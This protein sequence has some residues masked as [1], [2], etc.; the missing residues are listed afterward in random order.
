MP[1]IKELLN[2]LFTLRGV[3]SKKT[4]LIIEIIGI[5]LILSIWTIAA[6]LKNNHIVFPS[7]FDILYSFKELHFKNYLIQN[8]L[9]SIK[10]NLL[11]YLE[12][13]VIAIPIGFVLGLFPLFRALFSKYINAIRFIPLTAITGL[14]ILWFGIGMNMKIQF[15]AVGILVYLLPVIIQRI[16]DLENVYVQTIFTLG[17]SKWQTIKYVFIPRVLSKLSDDIRTLVAISWTYIIAA[18][19]LNQE[20]GI[21]ALAYTSART[22]RID[23]VFAI[24]LVIILVGFLQDKIFYK[25]DKLLFPHK[26]V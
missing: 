22:G 8:L 18:E 6:T 19:L 10:L 9:F 24:L 15:L 21:G 1:N 5:V 12:A 3:L 20:G 2:S 26:Y 4:S 13:I 17:A 7:V 14:F 16:D 23:K 11:G 25:I